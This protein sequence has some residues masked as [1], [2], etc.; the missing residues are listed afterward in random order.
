MWRDKFVQTRRK[1]VM[2]EKINREL[3]HQMMRRLAGVGTREFIPTEMN[4]RL[5]DAATKLA[6]LSAEQTGVDV[7]IAL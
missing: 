5:K 2:T 4:L 7:E 6:H 1:T 3:F